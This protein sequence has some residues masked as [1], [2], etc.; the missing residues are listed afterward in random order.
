[1]GITDRGVVELVEGEV[2]TGADKC[3]ERS[4]KVEKVKDQCG[5]GELY[6][7]GFIDGIF[8]VAEFV[9]REVYLFGS[10]A[11]ME[12]P[13]ENRVNINP[14]GFDVLRKG[15]GTIVEEWGG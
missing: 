2:F 12:V 9:Q 3:E 1:M 5:G 8:E 13:V 10:F 15:D 11:D 4:R 14:S 7:I 6:A